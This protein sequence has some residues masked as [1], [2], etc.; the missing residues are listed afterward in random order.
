MIFAAL[1]ISVCFKSLAPNMVILALVLR[2]VD[3][4][5]SSR[6][7]ISSLWVCAVGAVLKWANPM[8]MLL[9]LEA[10]AAV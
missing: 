5:L 4:T 8:D 6:T 10:S 2:P 3:Q 1:F 7:P 9:Y